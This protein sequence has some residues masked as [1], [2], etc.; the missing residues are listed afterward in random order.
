MFDPPLKHLSRF[1]APPAY[2]PIASDSNA[3]QGSEQSTVDGLS[4]NSSED[5]LEFLRNYDTV[6][7]VDDSG[8]MW[9]QRWEE[10]RLSFPSDKLV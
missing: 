9:G 4:V 3:E 6:F 10:V 7:I 1:T 8:S 5:A 2:S